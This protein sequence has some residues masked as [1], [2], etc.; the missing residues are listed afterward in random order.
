MSEGPPRT[1]PPALLHDDV[2]L[3]APLAGCKADH[4]LT[5][6]PLLQKLW[7]ASHILGLNHETRFTSL[8]LLHRYYAYSTGD[9][10]LPYK[11]IGA[12]CLVLGCKM[13]ET[14]RRLRDFINVAVMLD[15]SLEPTADST[16]TIQSQPPD[17][18]SDY[19]KAK[20]DLVAAEQAVLRVLA[21]E[22]T[23]SHPH[24]FVKLLLEPNSLKQSDLLP[25]AWRR[26]NDSVFW[27]PA[28]THSST[29]L[30]LAA[31]QLSREEQ[32]LLPLSKSDMKEFD[33]DDK[34]LDQTIGDLKKA[35]A[36][37]YNF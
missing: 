33:V 32:Q 6:E 28:L 8:V 10:G 34:N 15:F 20:E 25:G 27:A 31:I 17:L 12:A 30:A 35:T 16:V 5:L 19:W 4:H 2:E 1:L 18:N 21:F 9:E 3:L 36:R 37:L 24:R 13:E 26:L 29:E 22:V 14:S 23:I 11:W 7:I